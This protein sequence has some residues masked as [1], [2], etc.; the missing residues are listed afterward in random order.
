MQWSDDAT[1]RRNVLSKLLVAWG[2]LL[3]APIVKVIAE[4]VT[5]P[6]GTDRGA[7]SVL[8]ASVDDLS[9]N[10][11]RIFKV[12]KE[13]VILV[14][15]STGQ[16]RAFNARCTHLGCVVQYSTADGPPGFTCNCHGSEF[17]I[18]GKNIDGPA[19]RPLVPYRVIVRE[20]SIF[21]TKA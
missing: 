12:N 1:P 6:K 13:P 19:P 20:S 17:D 9:M 11:A 2:A 7:E 14:H 5:P 15:T 16:Y 4:F 10:S 21:V 8:I 3:L 18:T